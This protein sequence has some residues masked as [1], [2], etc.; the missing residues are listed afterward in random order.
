MPG[1]TLIARKLVLAVSLLEILTQI[2]LCGAPAFANA[3][4]NGWLDVPA[5][6]EVS[7]L[8][9]SRNNPNGLEFVKETT[10]K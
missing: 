3:V 9:A 8:A 5:L 1:A 10:V 6:T 2:P 4:T 7:G